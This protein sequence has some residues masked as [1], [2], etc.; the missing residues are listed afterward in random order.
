MRWTVWDCPTDAPAIACDAVVGGD[1]MLRKLLLGC[2]IAA[3]VWWVAMDLVGSLRYPGYS[4]IDQTI[5]ELGAEGAP[6]KAFMTVLSGVPY[7]VLMIAF[8]VGVWITAGGGRAQRITAA[9]LIGEAVWGFVGGIAFPTATRE[10]M[11]AGQETLRNQLH[12]PYGIGMPVLFGLAAAFRSRLFGKRFR[13]YS[14][15]TIVVLLVFGLLTSLQM[16]AVKANEATPWLGVIERTN[17]YAAM[18]W[19]AALA[20]GLLR[21]H[22]PSAPRQPA[23]PAVAPQ[24]V[25]R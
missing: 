6:T 9:L 3:P 25:P 16:G 7:V 12:G 5:S 14:I 19:I 24:P 22:A 23:E 8:G 17:A 21:V 20:M 18:L 15:G 4:Y 2:G 1:E 11:A 13:L 10:V